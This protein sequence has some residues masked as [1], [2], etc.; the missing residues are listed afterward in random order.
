M[1]S[2]VKSCQAV[3]G[4]NSVQCCWW[5]IR[6]P[7][8]PLLWSKKAV[9]VWQ[10]GIPL[11]LYRTISSLSS[12]E[13]F[14]PSDLSGQRSLD[15]RSWPSCLVPL[16]KGEVVFCAFLAALNSIKLHYSRCQL[17]H[18][19]LGYDVYW[20]S[21]WVSQIFL[22][23]T[24]SIYLFICKIRFLFTAISSILLIIMLCGLLSSGSPKWRQGRVARSTTWW[25]LGLLSH[26]P[27]ATD[28][29]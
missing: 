11:L 6:N 13:C 1:S 25:C 4:E 14:S 8:G 28:F 12:K 22:C 19:E 23:F 16:A 10:G 26:P 21:S 24:I 3:S 18:S 5:L 15:L 27:G 20:R 9:P 2:G 29:T 7:E 17:V